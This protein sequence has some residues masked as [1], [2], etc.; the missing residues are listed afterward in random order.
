[1]RVMVLRL[2]V[3]VLALFGTTGS[4]AHD[5]QQIFAKGPSP[6]QLSAGKPDELGMGTRGGQE[7]GF[8]DSHE[9]HRLFRRRKGQP[10]QG[11]GP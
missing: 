1:M 5:I 9:N 3:V 6:T 2:L 10:V 11:F 7:A 8:V 4:W